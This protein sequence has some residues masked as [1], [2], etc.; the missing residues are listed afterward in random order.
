MMEFSQ[1]SY[2]F[3]PLADFDVRDQQLLIRYGRGK[4]EY[5]EAVHQQFIDFKKAHD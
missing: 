3:I 2:L 1:V 4:W 5:N